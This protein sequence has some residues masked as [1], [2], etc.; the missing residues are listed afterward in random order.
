MWCQLTRT[1]YTAVAILEAVSEAEKVMTFYCMC[2]LSDDQDGAGSADLPDR[3]EKVDDFILG[4]IGS[5]LDTETT[6][7]KDKP[8]KVSYSPDSS[9][10]YKGWKGRRGATPDILAV[11]RPNVNHLREP[12]GC[13]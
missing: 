8:I 9:L 1:I 6:D 2:T 12:L 11:H 10:T 3:T 13:Q 5:I 7:D 4:E